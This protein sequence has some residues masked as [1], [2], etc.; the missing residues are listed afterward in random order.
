MW[1][2]MGPGEKADFV[3]HFFGCFSMLFLGSVLIWLRLKLEREERE[4]A[5]AEERRRRIE[6][7]K[8]K[9]VSHKVETKP[10][11]KKALP[12]PV[13]RNK[14]PVKKMQLE[15]G[16]VKVAV[17]LQIEGKEDDV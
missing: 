4:E 7:E 11:V 1:E 6:R 15:E 8:L 10:P 3:I 5:L 13:K 17:F 16:R 14:P 12:V 9:I 2:D